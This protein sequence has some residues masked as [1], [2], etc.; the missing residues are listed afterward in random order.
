MI[1]GGIYETGLDK[2]D[3]KFGL[4]IRLI[5]KLNNWD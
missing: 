3:G 4:D 5:R 2:L 1:V